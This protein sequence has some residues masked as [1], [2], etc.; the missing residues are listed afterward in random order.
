MTLTVNLYLS[1]DGVMQGPGAV[2]EDRSGGFDRGGWLAP[3]LEDPEVGRTIGGW[4][5]RADSL[6]MGRNTY[7]LMQPFWEPV[8]DPYDTVAFALNHLPKFLVTSRAVDAP[9]HNTRVLAGN[10]LEAI[11]ALKG[12]RGDMQVHG[13]YRLVH[14]LHNAGM[15]DEYRLLILPV[16]V[17]TGKHLFEGSSVPAG[18]QLLSAETLPAGAQYL[19]FRPTPYGTGEI[20]APKDA[21]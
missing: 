19:R 15:V 11:A 18:F 5:R 2:D 21:G 13:S 10:P 12:G 9:W 3:H 16:V 17:G 6:L 14:E 4:I 1:L 7:D 8:T 20:A